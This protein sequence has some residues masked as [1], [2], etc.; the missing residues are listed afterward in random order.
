MHGTVTIEYYKLDRSLLLDV[1]RRDVTPDT[2]HFPPSQQR[3]VPGTWE[4][5]DG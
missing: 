3:L 5:V 4:R 1:F 2:A